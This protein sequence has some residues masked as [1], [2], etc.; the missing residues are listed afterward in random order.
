M[1][2]VLLEYYYI[3]LDVKGEDILAAIKAPLFIIPDRPWDISF[4]AAVPGPSE[5][6]RQIAPYQIQ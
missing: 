6:R 5:D 1:F 3:L 4:S 2:L